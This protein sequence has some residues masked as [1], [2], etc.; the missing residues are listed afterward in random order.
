MWVRQR[1]ISNPTIMTL[2][3]RSLLPKEGSVRSTDLCFQAVA[4]VQMLLPPLTRLAFE[5]LL[6][7][8]L[9]FE[10]LAR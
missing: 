4:A 7:L 6:Q 2:R 8:S 1:K 3:S 5:K 10:R 9:C